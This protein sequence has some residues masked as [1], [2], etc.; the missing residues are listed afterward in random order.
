MLL[1]AGVEPTFGATSG[2]AGSFASPAGVPAT[3][4]PGFGSLA[5]VALALA[6]VLG[7][8]FALAWLLRRVRAT[9]RPG[10]PGIEILADVALGAKE[11]A[12]LLQVDRARLL[13][14]VAA[15]QVR[16]LHVLPDAEPLASSNEPQPGLA[17]APAFAELLR[18]S[19]GR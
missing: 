6:L 11:R 15:G 5:Q 4:P 16:T 7:L 12:V 18:R 13:V 19:L 14:G 10:A 3:P 17:T 1:V 2:A 9:H 8:L